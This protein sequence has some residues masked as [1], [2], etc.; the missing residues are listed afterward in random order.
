MTTSSFNE[1]YERAKREFYDKQAALTRQRLMS[2][3]TSDLL[4]ELQRAEQ[5]TTMTHEE[6]KTD[7]VVRLLIPHIRACALQDVAIIKEVMQ[8][9]ARLLME[10]VEHL[11]QVTATATKEMETCS[12]EF[13]HLRPFLPALEPDTASS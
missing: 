12:E 5:N 7:D 4:G 9:R 6:E 2:V 3:P 11:R 1:V 10:R 8:Q 13:E